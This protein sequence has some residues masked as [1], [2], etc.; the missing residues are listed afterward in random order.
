MNAPN[1]VPMICFR[2]LLRRVTE[3]HAIAGAALL[4]AVLTAAY[5]Q[6]QPVT[7]KEIQE[8]WVNKTL[9]GT[10]ANGAPATIRLQADGSASLPG[11]P[12]E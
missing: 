3:R 11:R 7:P 6:E 8:T 1:P 5:A 9:V 10:T 4:S 2:S 12:H